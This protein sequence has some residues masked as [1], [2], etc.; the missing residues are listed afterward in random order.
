MAS[1][2]NE[3]QMPPSDWWKWVAPY[4]LQGVFSSPTVKR[5]ELGSVACGVYKLPSS[6]PVCCNKPG[7]C[8][9]DLTGE[10]SREAVASLGLL[11]AHRPKESKVAAPNG[12]LSP[13][14]KEGIVA[15][16]TM[17]WALGLDVN[18]HRGIL[19]P[20][21][22]EALG[23]VLAIYGAE[24]QKLIVSFGGPDPRICHQLSL[25]FASEVLGQAMHDDYIM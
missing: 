25:A 18:K 22:P 24:P 9:T 3:A 20:H 13:Y 10:H 5:L 1:Q 11:F 8:P 15:H 12:G 17:L 6:R 2:A 4:V 23:S 7:L 21:D 16:R 14:A 19:F